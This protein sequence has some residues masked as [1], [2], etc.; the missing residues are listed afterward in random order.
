MDVQQVLAAARGGDEQ[1]RERLLELTRP[2]ALSWARG[3]VADSATAE[4]VTQEALLEVWNTLASL[5]EPEAY[6]AWVRLLV[7]KHADRH[8][9]KLRTVVGLDLLG[10]LP[11]VAAGPADSAIRADRERLVRRMLALAPDADRRLLD[12]R[13]VAGWPDADLAEL[14]GISS[15]AV[16]KR[17]FDA[18]QRLKP[19]L[20]SALEVPLDTRRIPMTQRFGLVTDVDAGQLSLSQPTID[21]TPLKTGLRVFDALLPWPRAGLI[22]LAGPV[23]TGGLVLL[24]E[25]LSELNR[26][27]PAAL[28]GVSAVNAA[29]DGSRGRLRKIVEDPAG[30]PERSRIFRGEP[31][32]AL[33]AAVSFAREL[34]QEGVTVLLVVDRVVA[35]AVGDAVLADLPLAL[36][37]GSVTVVRL[38]YW[39]RDSEPIAL[40][41]AAHT[42]VVLSAELGLRGVYPAVDLIASSSSL[43]DPSLAEAAREHLLRARDI[44]GWVA[45]SL[46]TAA[47]H[48]GVRGERFTPHEAVTQL[49]AV[50]T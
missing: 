17:L 12:L 31:E 37:H 38:S 35:E 43:A 4:D 49:R 6:F 39:A 27:S 42:T 40:W 16:R 28:V 3:L 29:E 9:R 21:T 5:R 2:P 48:T 32:P 24:G 44:E 26:Q 11:D 45:Q 25:V 18:R 36:A 46:M 47:E 13:Y 23:A 7:R 34:A 22:D 15:G 10:D 1:S 33:A 19:H 41:K 20:A 14:F 50:L 30:Q 8:R